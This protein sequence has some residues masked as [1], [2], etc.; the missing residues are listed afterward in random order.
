MTNHPRAVTSAPHSTVPATSMATAA[1]RS[2]AAASTNAYRTAL[3]GAADQLEADVLAIGAAL[4]RSDLAAARSSELAAQSAFD[5]LRAADAASPENATA[6]DALSGQVLSGGDF[7]GLHAVERDLWTDGSAGDA[8]RFL[9]SL[10][11]QVAVTKELMARQS[12]SPVVITTVAVSELNWVVDVPLAG[13]EEQYSHL[14]A[15]DVAGGVAG[16]RDAF[17]AVAPLA[18]AVERT[19][20]ETAANRLDALTVT[21]TSLGSPAALPDALLGADLQRSLS[22]Q[23]DGAADAL[24]ALE[25]PLIRFGVAGPEPYGT[26]GPS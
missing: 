17:A 22:Q 12:L 7:G 6:V 1:E 21:V 14:D 15:V 8:S 19:A 20:C 24:G 4:G 25:A 18:C 5:R 23:A 11:S 3:A 16:A 9:P 10:E 2:A 26:G 13:R